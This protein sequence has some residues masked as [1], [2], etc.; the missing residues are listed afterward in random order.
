MRARLSGGSAASDGTVWPGDLLLEVCGRDVSGMD[1]DN[2]MALLIDAPERCDLTFGRVRGKT[3]ALRF[4]PDQPLVFTQPGEPIMPLA[5]RAAEIDR[6]LA[7]LIE[8]AAVGAT[9]A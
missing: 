8:P 2:T 9:E 7:E 3:A 6:S 1:F 5:E 4:G